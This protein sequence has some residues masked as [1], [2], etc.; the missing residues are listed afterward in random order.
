[1]SGSAYKNLQM[2]GRLCGNISLRRA[3]LATTMWDIVKDRAVAERREEELSENFWDLLIA[4]G[5]IAERFDNTYRSALRIVDNL[6][7]MEIAKDELLIQEELVEQHKPLNETEAGKVLGSSFQELLL[8][9]KRTLKELAD[10]AKLQDDPTL[11]RSMQEEYDKMNIVSQKTFEEMKIPL[12]RRIILWF[13]G[14]R[15]HGVCS[16]SFSAHF[17]SQIMRIADNWHA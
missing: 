1:M 2:F 6:I 3:R 17:S 12:S 7:A 8:G 16:S 11:A 9:Q 4:Q 5:A 10:E 15:S 14:R 13:F